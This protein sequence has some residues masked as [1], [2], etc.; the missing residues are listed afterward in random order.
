MMNIYCKQESSE[1]RLYLNKI[2]QKSFQ[3]IVCA[4]KVASR[5]KHKKEAV[6]MGSPLPLK[7]FL[8]PELKIPTLYSF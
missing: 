1:K 5:S 7:N 8:I 2:L 4:G 6:F 3:T